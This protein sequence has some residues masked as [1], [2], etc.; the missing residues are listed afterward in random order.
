MILFVVLNISLCGIQQHCS[1]YQNRPEPSR[2]LQPSA[3]PGLFVGHQGTGGRQQGEGGYL[4]SDEPKGRNPQCWGSLLGLRAQTVGK[5]CMGMMQVWGV[6]LSDAPAALGEAEL[7]AQ[8]SRAGLGQPRGHCL[9]WILCLCFA[10]TP[11]EGTAGSKLT[12]LVNFLYSLWPFIILRS[13]GFFC[14]I[15][16]HS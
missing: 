8:G 4:P 5:W 2:E 9:L 12:S 10:A 1:W 13:G 11:R 15:F 6:Q 7:W 14:F 16:K 3:Q